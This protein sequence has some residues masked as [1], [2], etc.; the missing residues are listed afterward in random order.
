MGGGGFGINFI[1]AARNIRTDGGRERRLPTF[2][3]HNELDGGWN[4]ILVA[5]APGYPVHRAAVCWLCLLSWAAEAPWRPLAQRSRLGAKLGHCG[6]K[7]LKRAKR[8]HHRHG[9]EEKVWRPWFLWE[10]VGF[11]SRDV[12]TTQPRH[13]DRQTPGALL[14]QGYRL[15]RYCRQGKH[16][17]DPVT[18]YTLY[19]PWWL[20]L[21]FFRT[22]IGSK[23]IRHCWLPAR[24]I[25]GL[26]YWS[27]RICPGPRPRLLRVVWSLA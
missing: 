8:G 12:D 17:R 14:R 23:K 16:T 20:R 6:K 3:S 11:V 4:N 19:A 7:L 26:D 5:V 21:L 13:A 2:P 27:P 10:D 24:D 1:S 25:L 15:L 9:T 18:G 22:N